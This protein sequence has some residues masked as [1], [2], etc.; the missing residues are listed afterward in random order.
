VGNGDCVWT[1]ERR[2]KKRQEPWSSR[3]RVS[4]SDSL[5]DTWTRMRSLYFEE[6]GG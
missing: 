1:S 2:C 5:G 6:E 3:L 4:F